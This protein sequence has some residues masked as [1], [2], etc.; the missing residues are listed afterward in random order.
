MKISVERFGL[1]YNPRKE[2]RKHKRLLRL[3]F[4][5]GCVFF[6]LAIAFPLLF[7]LLI[8]KHI[9]QLAFGEEIDS[10]W[11]GSLA[12]YW[13]GIIG[14][15]LSGIIAFLGVYC[16]IRYYKE[17]DMQKEIASI[18]PFLLAAIEKGVKAE[19]G[20]NYDFS[21]RNSRRVEIMIKNIGKGFA[22]I[23]AI[24]TKTNIGGEAFNKVLL[25]GE[26][27]LFYIQIDPRQ[28]TE[29]V[30]FWIHY[31]DAMRNEYM[32]KYTLSETNGNVEIE[33]GYPELID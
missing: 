1:P 14:G 32:Q 33:S 20:Y 9:A 22:D 8:R 30:I 27:E 13:G 28:L 5:A 26:A 21:N 11:I 12:S 25:T 24:H 10:V 2:N 16:T 23:L 6:V 19:K 3:M 29:E 4:M 18:Q 7:E 17:S 31:I 15:I